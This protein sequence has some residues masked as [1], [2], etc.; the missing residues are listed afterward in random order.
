MSDDDGDEFGPGLSEP[1]S[2]SEDEE[3]NDNMK[4]QAALLRRKRMQ[5]RQSTIVQVSTG[6]LE[7]HLQSMKKQLKEH[8]ALIQ[9]PPFL[10]ELMVEVNKISG[11]FRKI[12]HCQLDVNN[13]RETIVNLSGGESTQSEVGEMGALTSISDRV[14]HL[15]KDLEMLRA[16]LRRVDVHHALDATVIVRVRKLEKDLKAL[17]EYS[18]KMF[19]N[20]M[21]VMQDEIRGELKS[22]NAR[23]QQIDDLHCGNLSEVLTRIQKTEDN[24]HEGQKEETQLLAKKVEFIEE[25]LTTDFYSFKRLVDGELQATKVISMKAF[26]RSSKGCLGVALGRMENYLRTRTLDVMRN[27][28]RVWQNFDPHGVLSRGRSLVN[29]TSR[30]HKKMFMRDAMFEWKRLHALQKTREVCVL[31]WRWC[32]SCC[33]L[34]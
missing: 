2:E 23:I 5:S 21:N 27:R 29:L 11:L 25:N 6:P 4:K 13:V 14:T 18:E 15:F 19:S 28:F 16:V 24:I 20:K 17:K 10:D 7:M 34:L 32:C 12:E 8:A 9:H 33:M 30:A 1:E 22:V 26:M 3:H 31:C